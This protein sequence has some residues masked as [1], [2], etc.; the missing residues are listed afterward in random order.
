MNERFG[1]GGI[2]GGSGTIYENCQR[3]EK[4]YQEALTLLEMKEKFPKE[5]ELIF[6]Y[7]EL[8]IYRFIPVLWEMRKS[9]GFE[10]QSL[11]CLLE[12]DARHKTQLYKT[13]EVYL[14]N[15][16]KI[17]ETANLLHIHANTLSYR[18][19]RIC[20][21]AEVNLDDYNQKITLFIELKINKFRK[22]LL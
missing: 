8:G 7:Q 16:S 14:E 22:S 10:N 9:D 13:L 15:D 4:S 21:I 1:V 12:Y 20:E 5:T 2:K 11:K 19:K 3:V 17:N 6:S 18:L